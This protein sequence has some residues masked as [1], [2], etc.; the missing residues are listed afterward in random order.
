[1][2]RSAAPAGLDPSSLAAAHDLGARGRRRVAR[3]HQRLERLR[4][5]RR[6]L[7]AGIGV[8]IALGVGLAVLGWDQVR[9]STPGQYVD[10]SLA[11][12]EPG[13]VALVEPT[14]TMLVATRDGDG[15]LAGVAL[16]ALQGDDEGGA[17][18]VMPTAIRTPVADA[19]RTEPSTDD[20]GT[21]DA[22]SADD[23][24]T[25]DSGVGDSGV[26]DTG[27]TTGSG[28]TSSTE[29]GAAGGPGGSGDASGDRD[30]GELGNVVAQDDSE[31]AEETATT[32]VAADQ[33]IAPEDGITLAAAYQD[34]GVDAVVTQVE[35]LLNV[36]VQESVELDAAGWSTLVEPVNPLSVTLDDAVLDWSAGDVDLTAGDVGPFLAAR[37]DEESELARLSR[38]ELFWRA[39]LPEVEAGGDQAVPGESSVGIGRFVRGLAAGDALVN[40]LPVEPAS[41]VLEEQFVAVQAMMVPLVAQEIPYPQEPTPGSR[42]KVRLLNGTGEED[43]AI[44]AAAPLV[45]A[46]AEISVTGNASSF[47]EEETRLV[48]AT[49][50][51]RE[52]AEALQAALG[53]GVVEAEQSDEGIPPTEEG[54]RIDVTVILGA[55]A[56]EAIGRLETPD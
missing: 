49:S 13:Y 51:Q 22:G 28:E 29:E 37:N 8:L 35:R 23:S 3:R 1:V 7:V 38:Q 47:Q 52:A 27:E 56:P 19:T 31:D 50:R 9:E 25:G 15:A 11:P 40:S 2:A 34:G 45:A 36:A 16:M 48:Y 41:D 24:G 20:A 44:H 12:D 32:T 26:G 43:L 33:G 39:W 42:I 5:S 4:R 17:V 6:R 10:P 21:D 30:L 54:D 14:P 53:I 46:G 18:L 55:D